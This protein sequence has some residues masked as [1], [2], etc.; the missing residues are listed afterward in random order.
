MSI[1]V[2]VALSPHIAEIL[3]RL[4]GD[5]DVEMFPPDVL[6]P[7]LDLRESVEAYLKLH[8]KPLAEA[9]ELYSRGDLLQA[10]ESTGAPPPCST[11][12]PRREAFPTTATETTTY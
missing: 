3:R 2:G 11:R 6:A 7:R 1:R 9:E 12:S 10:G 8:E 5:K 4:A